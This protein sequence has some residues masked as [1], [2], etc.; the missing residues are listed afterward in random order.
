MCELKT[1]ARTKYKE[2]S[3]LIPDILNNKTFCIS[4]FPLKERA[5]NLFPQKEDKKHQVFVHWH[6]KEI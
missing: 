6:Q 4:I 5:V 1:N 2:G 3:R